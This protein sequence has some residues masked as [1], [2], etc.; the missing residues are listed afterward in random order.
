MPVIG[1]ISA[2]EEQDQIGDAVRS[3]LDVGCKRVVV[4]DGAWTTTDGRAFHGGGALSRDRTRHEAEAAGAQYVTPQ[5]PCGSPR[6]KRTMLLHACDAQNGDHLLL[7]DADERAVGQLPAPDKLPAGHACVVRHNL[8]PEDLPG[9]R[10]TWPRGDGGP[11]VPMLRLI[12]WNDTL[13]AVRPGRLRD[14]GQLVEPY[15]V[16]ALTMI[17]DT[18]TDPIIRQAAAALRETEQHLT[19]E[20]ACALPVLT[21]LH[22]EHVGQ[23]SEQKVQAKRDYIGATT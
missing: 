3:L 1:A 18:M 4:L 19:P 8:R 13:E 17:A 7:L 23:P 15:L 22:L 10:G 12:R 11:T 21:T 14:R 5:E 16:T 6:R 20:L 9:L 2:F